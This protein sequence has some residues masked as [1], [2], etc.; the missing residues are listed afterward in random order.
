[1]LDTSDEFFDQFFCRNESTKK[2]SVY[3]KLKI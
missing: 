1:M 3:M 2:K